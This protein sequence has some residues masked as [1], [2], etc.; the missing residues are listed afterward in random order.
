M[1]V[2]VDSADYHLARV[3]ADTNLHL[4]AVGPTHLGAVAP[5]GLL[6]G[7]SSVTGTHGVILV[8]QWCPKQRHDAVAHDLV[9]RPFIAVHGRHQALEDWVEELPRFLGI[10]VS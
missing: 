3:Q 4:D 2:V 1:Q 5:H 10:A 8:G 9:H 7:Q 6:H